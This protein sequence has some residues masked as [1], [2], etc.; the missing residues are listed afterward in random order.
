[1]KSVK[2]IIIVDDSGFI[3]LETE[4]TKISRSGLILLLQSALELAK[5]GDPW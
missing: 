3:S 4:G 5:K 2:V 1:M